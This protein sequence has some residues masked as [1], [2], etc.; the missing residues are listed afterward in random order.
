MN[1]GCVEVD[2]RGPT[3]TVPGAAGPF[4]LW[5]PVGR[6]TW[7]AVL[8]RAPGLPSHSGVGPRWTCRPRPRGLRDGP[9]VV[10]RG[11]SSGLALSLVHSWLKG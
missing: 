9:L 5:V 6:P 7:V 4:L 1:L 8:G 3:G 2:G 11:L 10:G